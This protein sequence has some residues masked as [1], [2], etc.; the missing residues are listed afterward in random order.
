MPHKSPLCTKRQFT[1]LLVSL[2]HTHTPFN[3]ADV[4]SWAFSEGQP[5]GALHTDENGKLLQMS[6]VGRNMDNASL[7]C[8]GWKLLHLQTFQEMFLRVPQFQGQ[9][10]CTESRFR[11]NRLAIQKLQD[12]PGLVPCPSLL[13]TAQILCVLGE[14]KGR[15]GKGRE[16]RRMAPTMPFSRQIPGLPG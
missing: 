6:P 2:S 5:C 8:D 13:R 11:Q 10:E 12:I 15:E 16:R 3:I 7:L 9:A 4:S 1:Q 14:R